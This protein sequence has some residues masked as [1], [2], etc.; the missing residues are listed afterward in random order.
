M[1]NAAKADGQIDG[2]EMNN[3]LG[4]LDEAGAG[5]DAKDFVLAEMRRPLDLDGLV[6]GV[7]TPDLAAAVYAASAMAIKVDTPAEQNYL[8]QLATRLNLRRRSAPASTPASALAESPE[9]LGA[10]VGDRRRA[11]EQPDC[12]RCGG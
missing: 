3:I 8:G 10:R 2:T 1:I 4:K 6:A 7:S 9:G 5:Q 11:S 12:A